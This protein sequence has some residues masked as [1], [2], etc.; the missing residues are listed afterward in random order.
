MTSRKVTGPQLA[1]E[2]PLSEK[3]SIGLGTEIMALIAMIGTN[4]T[5]VINKM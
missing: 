4:L 5:L 2:T 1:L 3:S